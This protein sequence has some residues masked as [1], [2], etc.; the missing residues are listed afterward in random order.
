MM[1]NASV[2]N[3][4][5]NTFAVFNKVIFH[6]NESFFWEGEDIETDL[7]SGALFKG[8]EKTSAGQ[9][10]YLGYVLFSDVT[11]DAD[12][13]DVGKLTISDVESVDQKMRELMAADF[14]VA[15]F[16]PAELRTLESGVDALVSSCL[17]R[18]E[19]S[20]TLMKSFRFRCQEI[21]WIAVCAF[22]TDR[23]SDFGSAVEDTINTAIVR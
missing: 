23:Q 20:P 22:H 14:E 11:R 12:E 7:H 1:K 5:T 2:V 15:E 21:N 9:A 13:P 6:L 4:E 8:F 3:A 16:L 10:N 18:S 17:L 19:E